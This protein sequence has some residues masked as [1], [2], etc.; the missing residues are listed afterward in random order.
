MLVPHPHP[1][2]ASPTCL[3]FANL[4]AGKLAHFNSHALE[5]HFFMC[6]LATY[7][8]FMNWFSCPLYILCFGFVFFT[9]I[10]KS[11]LNTKEMVFFKYFS[12]LLFAFVIFFTI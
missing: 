10:Y 12:G 11:S 1:S 2:W 3:I 9:E 5:V 6:L 7:I 8:S 4:T